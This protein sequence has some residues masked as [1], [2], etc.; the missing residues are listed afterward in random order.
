MGSVCACLLELWPVALILMWI[1]S[2]DMP[3]ELRTQWGGLGVRKS[4]I[5]HLMVLFSS[6]R[7]ISAGGLRVKMV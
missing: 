5:L 2:G 1:S 4:S 7:L 6:L 3:G